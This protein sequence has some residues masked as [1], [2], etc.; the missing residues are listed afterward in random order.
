M[1][2]DEKSKALFSSDAFGCFGALSGNIFADELNYDCE[3]YS[4]S[5]RYYANIVGK[6]GLQVLN[7]LKKLADWI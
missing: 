1:V 6:F 7:I 3:W 4:E 5:R 2:Y